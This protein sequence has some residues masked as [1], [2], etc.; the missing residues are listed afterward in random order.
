MDLK[1][2]LKIVRIQEGYYISYGFKLL[3]IGIV[4]SYYNTGLFSVKYINL[5]FLAVVFY[6]ES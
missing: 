5:D 6:A 2:L 3:L 1:D 4:T